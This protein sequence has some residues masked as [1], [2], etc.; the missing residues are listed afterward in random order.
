MTL[1]AD[2]T[3]GLCQ[4]GNRAIEIYQG[5]RFQVHIRLY[6]AVPLAHF[7]LHERTSP[8]DAAG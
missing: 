4:E 7:S 8:R 6:Q 5:D 3:M 2:Q 1:T